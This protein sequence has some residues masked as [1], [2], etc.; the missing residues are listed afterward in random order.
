MGEWIYGPARPTGRAESPPPPQG[1]RKG[2]P[3]PMLTALVILALA[4][5]LAS[6]PESQ[7][8]YAAA[9]YQRASR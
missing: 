5:I 2:V 1:K 6:R 7:A 4:V 3:R 9:T 8:A